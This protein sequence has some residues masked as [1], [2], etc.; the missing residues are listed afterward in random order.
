VKHATQ[1]KEASREL[2]FLAPGDLLQS[3]KVE[4]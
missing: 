3:N 1:M 4:L 2:A